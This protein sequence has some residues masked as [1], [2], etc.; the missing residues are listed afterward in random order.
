MNLKVYMSVFQNGPLVILLVVHSSSI[1]QNCRQK[2]CKPIAEVGLQLRVDF[3]SFFN[4][5]VDFLL[6]C[7]LS[8]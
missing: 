8:F 7:R 2:C 6:N 3:F 5:T 1:V 4:F